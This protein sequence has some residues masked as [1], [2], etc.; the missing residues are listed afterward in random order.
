MRSQKFLDLATWRFCLVAAFAM[1]AWGAAGC[2]G[3]GT[4]ANLVPVTGNITL[5]GKPLVGASVTFVG[6]GATPGLGGVGM[7]D[8]AGN[9]EVSHFRAGKGL[10]PGDYKVLVSKVVMSDGSPIPAGTLS[11]AELSTRELVPRRY[12]DPNTSLL[13]HTVRD[14]GQPMS[15]SLASR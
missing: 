6:T 4:N 3:E 14:G 10:D 1:A 8:E 15:L 12:N 13:S 7:T 11:I 9:F 5:D 2:T